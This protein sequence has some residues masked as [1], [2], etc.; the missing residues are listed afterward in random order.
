MLGLLGKPERD[1][2]KGKQV[3]YNKEYFT[4]GEVKGALVVEE[5]NYFGEIVDVR[6]YTAE[7]EGEFVLT[8]AWDNGRASKSY[9]N[10][11]TA[12]RYA[13]GHW[14]RQAIW[15]ITPNG[16]KRVIRWQ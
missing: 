14:A 12:M 11:A 9:D 1:N 3:I 7:V 13:N 5:K 15:H 6:S 16:R 10:F 8:L 4:K 2:K